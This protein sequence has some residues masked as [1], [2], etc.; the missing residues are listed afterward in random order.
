MQKE[1]PDLCA[2]FDTK[3]LFILHVTYF[4]EILMLTGLNFAQ[5]ES[6][7]MQTQ[8]NLCQHFLLLQLFISCLDL[9]ALW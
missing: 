2:C 9:L 5:I 8:K 3:L 6:G 4:I 7:P 1:H